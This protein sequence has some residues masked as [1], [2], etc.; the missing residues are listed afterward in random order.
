MSELPQTADLLHGVE[1]IAAFLELGVRQTRHLADT[2]DL[3]TFRL[4]GR[5]CARRASLVRWIEEKE[6]ASGQRS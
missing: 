1:A 2:T 3:P 4:G 5:V 6:A